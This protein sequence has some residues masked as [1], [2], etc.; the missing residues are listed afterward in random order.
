MKQVL[1]LPR[2]GTTVIRDVP[3]PICAAGGLLVRNSFSAISS[4]TERAR[5]DL[6]QKSLLGKARDRPDLA[7]QV[8]GK[9]RQDGVIPTL[10]TVQERLDRPVPV[11]YSSA[12]TVAQVGTH[13]SGFKV[14]DRVACAGAG[15]ANHAEYV[16]VPANLCAPVPDG[17]LLQD[18]AV[19]T[20]ASIALHA[21]R[22]GEVQVGSRVAVVGCGLV[23]QLACRLLRAAGGFTIALDI[24]PA[25]VDDACS[26]GADVG[27]A[28]D[29]TTPGR[30]LSA[31]DMAGADTVLVTAAAPT[32]SPLVTAAEI[33]RDRGLLVLVG[34]VPV[35]L[36][37]SLLY[38]KE[39]TLRVSRSY[40]PGRYDR[41]YE[42]R[43]LD[44]PV[45]YVRWTEQRNMQ[46]VLT[47]QAQGALSFS[48]LIEVSPVD[49][50]PEV[51]KRLTGDAAPRPRGAVVLAYTDS[52]ESLD[53]PTQRVALGERPPD[54]TAPTALGRKEGIG[55]RVVRVGL[56]GPG[57]FATRVLVPGLRAAKAELDAVAGAT[58]PSAIAAADRG[59][60]RR[61][62]STA[63]ELARDPTIDA[64]VI[65]TRHTS[66]ADLASLALAANK[67]VFCEKP[68]ALTLSERNRVVDAAQKSRGI[69]L[70]GYNRRFSPLV[71]QMHDFLSLDPVAPKTIN[72]RVSAGSLP[73]E[74]WIHDL[75]EGGGRIIGEICHF[76]DTLVYLCN[77]HI[78]NIYAVGHSPTTRP[79]Q[80]VDNLT[81]SVRL[82]NSSVGSIVYVADGSPGVPKERLEGFCGGRSAILDDYLRLALFDGDAS[83]GRQRGRRQDKGHRAELAAFVDAVQTGIPPV[84]LET[85]DNVT[86]ASFAIIQ[87]LQ[88]RQPVSL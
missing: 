69:L 48:D 60:F 55:S 76:L 39:L 17:V 28:V 54:R 16:S 82:A 4:G 12:G 15:Y 64:V 71:R 74:H 31:T 6:S 9:A 84:P 70:V 2:D 75:D 21:I 7:R 14:G 29:A 33:A 45:G 49:H 42:E 62:A 57:N 40:G 43:G 65:S 59:H 72:Y 88:T 46:A 30:V 61:V 56:I 67:H 37:R 78:T 11:G 24:D 41:N 1:Q 50:A 63:S 18:A 80:A 22:L 53:R 25:R 85:H 44:Y 13:V 36:P 8:I 5:V 83:R 32:N 52:D 27:F 73:E 86:L 51:Y 77:S 3:V 87:S 79:L 66:H 58:G 20:I 10:R 35:E 47:L 38:E 68:L 34:S 19:T 23:G 26:A 81:V